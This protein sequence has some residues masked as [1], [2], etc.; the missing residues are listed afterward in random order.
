MTSKTYSFIGISVPIIFWTTYLIMANLRV[1]YSL[2]TKAVSELGSLD[3]PNKWI[4]NI[5]GYIIPGSF[6][7]IFSF[8]LYKNISGGQGSKVP[9]LGLVLSGIFMALSGIFPGDFENRQSFTMVAHTIGSIGSYFFYLLGAFSLPRLMKKSNY[10]QNSITPTLFL[11][12]LTILF[13]AWPVL[14]PNFPAVGQRLTFFFFFSWICFMAVKLY[15]APSIHG[16]RIKNAGINER[17]N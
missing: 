14:F 12:W 7:A 17:I 9:L 5:C 2:F 10:W 13:G 8:G 6:I 16:E 4:W 11:T 15:R 3:A 1:D